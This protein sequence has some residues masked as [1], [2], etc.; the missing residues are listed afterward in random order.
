MASFYNTKELSE[1]GFKSVGKN[2]LI[3][4]KASLYGVSR[5]SIG[6][7][8]RIDDFCF[9]SAGEGG[10]IIGNYVHISA[11]SSLVGQGEIILEDFVG[12][13]SKVTIYSSSDDFYG[14][15]MS[16][17]TVPSEFTGVISA[18]VLLCKHVLIGCGAVVLPGVT[19]NTGAA[20][21]A[22]SLVVDDCDSFY[23]YKG[24]PA[25]KLLKRSKKLLELEKEFL[26]TLK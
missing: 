9:L 5:I 11:Y 22:L 10:I 13:S 12:I 1:L 23:I 21:G 2:I 25:T 19:I 16:N 17:P 15:Y 6:N 20:I 14:E 18:P 24:N 4:R 3:S 26:S 8:V 7:N